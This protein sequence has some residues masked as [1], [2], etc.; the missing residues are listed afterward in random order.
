[1]VA[2]QSREGAAGALGFAPF[3]LFFFAAGFLLADG[4]DFF[5]GV[6]IASPVWKED[7]R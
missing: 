7:A 1:M 5:L 4:A 3:P 6:A 2:D